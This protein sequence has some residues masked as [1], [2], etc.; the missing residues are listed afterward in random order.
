MRKKIDMVELLEKL[1]KEDIQ[2][3]ALL[4]REQYKNVFDRLAK[5]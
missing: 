3:R 1:S 2:K 4:F 5:L